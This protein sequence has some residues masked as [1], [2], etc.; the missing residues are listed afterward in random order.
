MVKVLNPDEALSAGVKLWILPP[1][2]FSDWTKQLDWPLNLQI[3]KA[4]HRPTQQ[5]SSELLSIL[6]KN[7]M[8][9][10]FEESEKKNLI[11]ATQ[12][13]LP[14]EMIVIVSG[15][16]WETWSKA[17]VRVWQDLGKPTARFFLPAFAKWDKVKGSWSSSANVEEVQIVSTE[18]AA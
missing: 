15:E 8:K 18:G 13:L 10:G 7:E 4:A 14:A 11:I 12:G 5:P 17:A 16:T 1:S 6:Q 9:F 3:S 2:N